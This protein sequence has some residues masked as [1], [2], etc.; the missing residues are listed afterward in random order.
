MHDGVCDGVRDGAPEVLWPSRT[1]CC[2]H[3]TACPC[4]LAIRRSRTPCA[5][6]GLLAYFLLLCNLAN[7]LAMAEPVATGGEV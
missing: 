2:S 7:A 5:I 6:S 1:G 4:D 3:K